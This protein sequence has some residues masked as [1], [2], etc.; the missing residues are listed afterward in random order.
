MRTRLSKNPNEYDPE[1]AEI[2]S[3]IAIR[4]EWSK[5]EYGTFL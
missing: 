4:Q 1:I 5:T 2:I 3:D